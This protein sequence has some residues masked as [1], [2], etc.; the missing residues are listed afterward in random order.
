MN[1]QLLGKLQGI[2]SAKGIYP[3]EKCIHSFVR[4]IYSFL[5]KDDMADDIEFER[6]ISDFKERLKKIITKDSKKVHTPAGELVDIFFNDLTSITAQ[7]YEDAKAILAFD[8]ATDSLDEV[9]HTYPG[10]YAITIY[11][12]AHT[13]WNYGMVYSA[14]IAS[15]YV[16]SQTGIDIHPGAE[17]GKSFAIDHG[18]GIVIGETCVIGNNVKLYQGV[19]LG[20]LQVAKR[21]QSEKRHP[22]IDD[23]V[24]IYSNATIL[25]GETVIGAG[26]TIGG[27]V[28]LTRSIAPCSLVYHKK[29]VIVKD[30]DLKNEPINFII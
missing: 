6:R 13:W 2:R 23:F 11:R 4:D 5:F 21:F 24:T 9:I 1:S 18:T 17:I 15:E 22:T 28:W 10:F 19:T 3:D 12:I 16:H 7:C 30:K 20:A 27:N 29:E 26:S 25:G 8:P 14:R